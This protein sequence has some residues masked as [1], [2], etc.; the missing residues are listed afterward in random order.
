MGFGGLAAGPQNTLRRELPTPLEV[1]ELGPD[2][3]PGRGVRGGQ[4]EP[5]GP[6]PPA[7]APMALEHL[8][9]GCKAV[10]LLPL[11]LAR[12]FFLS[13]WKQCSLEIIVLL[14]NKAESLVC[15]KK[16]F[17]FHTQVLCL[18]HKSPSSAS[19]LPPT[20]LL[21]S[22]PSLRWAQAGGEHS[23]YCPRCRG[24]WGPGDAL[25]ERGCTP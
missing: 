23:H 12:Y 4:P 10:F 7:K 17:F 9:C 6:P 16:I 8:F 21:A 2:Q 1:R 19:V 11:P 18:C 13:F 24:G 5:P 22:V 3:A 25:L 20:F 15:S 14:G